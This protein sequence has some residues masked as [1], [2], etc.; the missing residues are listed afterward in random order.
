MPLVNS[1]PPPEPWR[2]V[3]HS[4]PALARL[5]AALYR[6]R[7]PLFRT[8]PDVLLPTASRNTPTP[9]GAL[10]LLWA[11]WDCARGPC[12]ACGGPAVATAFGG[13]LSSGSVGGF[14]TECGTPVIRFIGGIGRVLSGC[15]QATGGTRWQVRIGSVPGQWRL[16]GDPSILIAVL[17]EVGATALPDRAAVRAALHAQ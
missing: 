3:G 1:T 7:D 17:Q 4:S 11:N 8:Y 15:R 2:A 12:P 14:C 16:A 9:L 6:Y 13:V 5:V 10:L